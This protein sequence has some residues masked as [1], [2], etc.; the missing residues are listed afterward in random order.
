MDLE[1]EAGSVEPA[2]PAKPKAPVATPVAAQPAPKPVAAP[3]NKAAP[4]K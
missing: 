3:P 1:F 2:P 4:K